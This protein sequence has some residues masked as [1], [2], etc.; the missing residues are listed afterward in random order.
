MKDEPYSNETY[1]LEVTADGSQVEPRSYIPRVNSPYVARFPFPKD[2]AIRR[3]MQRRAQ[4]LKDGET[5]ELWRETP[6]LVC[7]IR[8]T[9]RSIATMPDDVPFGYSPASCP[10]CLQAIN[11]A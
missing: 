10:P 2:N 1:Y 8:A 3:F 5:L 4:G 7:C 9:N 11:E 6:K